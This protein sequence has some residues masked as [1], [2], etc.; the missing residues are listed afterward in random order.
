MTDP[1]LPRS[2]R[3]DQPVEREQLTG[4]PEAIR[5]GP[6][7][8]RTP[9]EKGSTDSSRT[10]TVQVSQSSVSVEREKSITAQSATE[11]SGKS[12]SDKGAS[13]TIPSADRTHFQLR[14]EGPPV[15]ISIVS[16]RKIE[17]GHKLYSQVS[18]GKKIDRPT[19]PSEAR[20]PGRTV[21]ESIKVV[22]DLSRNLKA[23][24]AKTISQTPER[25]PL[26]VTTPTVAFR[27]NE[28]S[29][30][31]SKTVR[32]EFSPFLTPVATPGP[33][34][35]TLPK[36]IRP[37][38]SLFDVHKELAIAA[39]EELESSNGEELSVT[40]KTLKKGAEFIDVDAIIG[41]NT[42]EQLYFWDDLQGGDVEID[43]EEREGDSVG[44]EENRDTDFSEESEE[45]I[46]MAN[47]PRPALNLP[48]FDGSVGNKVEAYINEM[49][50]L[51]EI[52]GWNDVVALQMMKFGL[53]DKAADW[54]RALPDNQKDTVAHLQ[55]E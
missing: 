15:P 53:K 4:A 42:G 9:S 27:D 54:I 26:P 3:T 51:T 5:P 30:E 52:C 8:P 12:N 39:E 34:K 10:D 11:K 24:E 14:S 22:R 29:P 35:N 7:Q 48:S 50:T 36:D 31:L 41:Q 46:I 23:S 13:K 45:E 1:E 28:Q 18:S 40:A 37:V 55:E 2:K 49:Q 16:D 25:C 32:S 6:P 19:V 20:T 21:S 38:R 47:Q 44:E 43:I 17:T 33:S